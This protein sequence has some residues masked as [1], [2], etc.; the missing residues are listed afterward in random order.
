MEDALTLRTDAQIDAKAAERG[1]HLTLDGV[2]LNSTGARL[3]AEEFAQAIQSLAPP[4]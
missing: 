3:V 4:A 1:L 2:H